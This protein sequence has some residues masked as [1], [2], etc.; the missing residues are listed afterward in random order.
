MAGDKFDHVRNRLAHPLLPAFAPPD[1]RVGRIL[2]TLE[3]LVQHGEVELL[4]GRE[5][6]QQRRRLDPD[7][8]G[9][10]AQ[11][12]AMI[13]AL[14]EERLRHLQH[15]LTRV[16]GTSQLHHPGAGARG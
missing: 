5:M 2:D 4:L 10:V 15:T 6:M 3:Q 7:S 13:A 16:D 14:G 12:G 11:A 8:L 9:D 1:D